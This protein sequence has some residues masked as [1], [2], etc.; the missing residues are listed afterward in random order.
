MEVGVGNN[1]G[2][3][4]PVEVYANR[5]EES[6][7]HIGSSGNIPKSGNAVVKGEATADENGYLSVDVRKSDEVKGKTINVNW[8]RIYTSEPIQ[9]A[10]LEL[11]LKFDGNVSDTSGKD[12]PIA[13]TGSENYIEGMNGNALQ[14]DGKTYLNQGNS[15]SLQPSMLTAAFW[16]KAPEALGKG[17]HIIMWAKPNGNYA[18]EGW[19]LSSLSDTVPLKLSVRT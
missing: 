19:Y 15:A 12:L 5:G 8:I 17:E 16:V 14:L 13:L 11:Q 9:D 10:D 3:S 6:E 2:N 7:Q 1:W 4:S 18:G